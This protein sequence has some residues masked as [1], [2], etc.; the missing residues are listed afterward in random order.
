MDEQR[1]AMCDGKERFVSP[2]LAH[3]VLRKRKKSGKGAKRQVYRC[4]HCSGWHIGQPDPPPPVGVRTYRDPGT[5]SMSG[6][7]RPPPRH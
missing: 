7:R 2:Q 3:D 5:A 4:K 1:A 6:I